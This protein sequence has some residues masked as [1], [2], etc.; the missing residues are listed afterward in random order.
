[1]ATRL[2]AQKAA[3]EKAAADKAAD[4]RAWTEAT[5]TG[6]LAA[7]EAYAR[8]YPSGAHVAEAQQRI[9][10]LQEEARRATETAAQ[11]ATQK[12]AE[13]KAAADKAADD[14]AWAEATQAGSVAAFETYIRNNTAG[15]R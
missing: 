3:E 5:Q 1:T 8:A 6:A 10:A 4:D 9:A 13:E 11:L 2:A 12:A 7:F 14:R 15:A